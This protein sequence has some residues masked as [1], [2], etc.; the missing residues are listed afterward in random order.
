MGLQRW[1]HRAHRYLYVLLC[2]ETDG[3]CSCGGPTWDVAYFDATPAFPGKRADRADWVACR[4][5]H[6]AP[7][8][9][10]QWFRSLR[11]IQRADAERLGV[12]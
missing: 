1:L 11:W 10:G 7:T 5:C 3:C 9:E 4:A 12:L 2:E 6:E 8:S